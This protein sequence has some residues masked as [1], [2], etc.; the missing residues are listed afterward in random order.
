MEKITFKALREEFRATI[1]AGLRET[2]LPVIDAKKLEVSKYATEQTLILDYIFMVKTAILQELTY[3]LQLMEITSTK[4]PVHVKKLEESDYIES[5]VTKFGKALILT[6]KGHQLIKDAS[7]TDLRACSDGWV[8]AEVLEQRKL[9][10]KFLAFRV[11][12]QTL[13]SIDASFEN[14]SEDFKALYRKENE[15]IVKLSIDNATDRKDLCDRQLFLKNY[16]KSNSDMVL[17]ILHRELINPAFNFL[18]NDK[19]RSYN[20]FVRLGCAT[21]KVKDDYMLLLVEKK[22]LKLTIMRR[23]YLNSQEAKSA[24][25]ALKIS[26]KIERI[27]E[28]LKNLNMLKGALEENLT[29]AVFDGYSDIGNSKWMNTPLTL[30][31]L[32]ERDIFIANVREKPEGQANFLLWGLLVKSA[33][34][35]SAIRLYKNLQSIDH[36]SVYNTHYRFDVQIYVQS[37]KE[38]EIIME[39]LQEVN[40]MARQIGKIMYLKDKLLHLRIVVLP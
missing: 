29:E 14:E 4:V 38:A 40:T 27:D 19:I 15:E 5:R 32:A 23:N 37:E 18:R 30:A 20:Y 31:S 9:I 28:E 13:L 24:E 6:P 16:I 39:K 21:E 3:A 35:Y 1:A 12:Q 8:K 25:T 10:N 34:E 17:K 2:A 26:E 22:I 36:Y 11:H 33:E 7:K